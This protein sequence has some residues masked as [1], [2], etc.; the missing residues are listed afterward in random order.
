MKRRAFMVSALALAGCP[1]APVRDQT[2][3]DNPLEGLTD[4]SGDAIEAPKL[5]GRVTLVDFW[6]SWC[7]PCRQAFLYLN[8]LRGT[9]SPDELGMW[10]ISVDEDPA[11]G[12]AFAAR[13]RASFDVAWD[14]SG[15][16]RERFLVQGLPTTLLIDNEGRLV[17]RTQ[18]FD[19]RGHALVE[20]QIFRLLRS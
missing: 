10:A 6:A 19:R 17:H 20:S 13:F 7:G 5:L 9:Y 14:P 3:P 15:A 18:G 4:W 1:A 11:A 8:Q 16:I 12:R 2:R